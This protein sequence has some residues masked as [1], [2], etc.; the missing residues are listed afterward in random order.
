M[1]E[2]VLMSDPRVAA[3]GVQECGEPLLDVRR[4]TLLV[5]NSRSDAAG[6]FAH[7]RRSVLERLLTAQAQLPAGLRLL[8][9][10]GY[11][12]PALQARYFEEYAADLRTLNPAWS[13]DQ[14]RAGASRY[15]APPEIGPHTA[16]AA[17]DITLADTG[18]RELDL[19]TST[20]ATPE[21]SDG[22]CYTAATNI[23]PR[24]RELRQ[25]L[26]TALTSA[27]L[28]NYPSEWWHWSYGDRYWALFTGASSARYGP[29]SLPRQDAGSQV[30]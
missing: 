14:V 16:G 18:G 26:G 17:V 19:G 30:R 21:E 22:A 11:R 13:D 10:E 5:D 28:V 20:N 15:V 12:P 8:V 23:S 27:G 29:C 25:V 1:N 3:I 24:S 6:A 4:S 7:L 9:V 2:I